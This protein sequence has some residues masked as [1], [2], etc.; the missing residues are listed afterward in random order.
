MA[1]ISKPYARALFE[2]ALGNGT[3]DS[4]Y[5]EAQGLLSVFHGEK[6]LAEVIKNPGIPQ[7]KKDALIKKI[8]PD[9]NTPTKSMISLMISK[10]REAHIKAAIMG[11]VE[12]AKEHMGIVDAKVYSAA[13]LS[14]EQLE[15]LKSKLST[16]MNKQVEIETI[17]DPSLIGGLLIKAGSVIIDNTIK[18]HLRVL[19]NHLAIN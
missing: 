16:G 12:L 11:F 3:L 1:E 2:L 14:E 6:R 10:G 15:L 8:F 17:V 18:K 5:K 13:V 19:K 9:L 7:K 4:V